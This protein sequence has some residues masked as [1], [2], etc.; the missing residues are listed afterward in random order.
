MK[1]A[2]NLLILL[3]LLCVGCSPS[4]EIQNSESEPEISESE[5]D[6]QLEE[7][8]EI[9][10]SNIPPSNAGQYPPAG[11][12]D[13]NGKMFYLNDVM[14]NTGKYSVNTIQMKKQSSYM[15]NVTEMR[16]V[17]LTITIMKNEYQAVMHKVPEVY[18]S[19][20]VN[21]WNDKASHTSEHDNGDS[22]VYTFD[23]LLDYRYY[24]I[25]NESSYAQY[26]TSITWTN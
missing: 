13:V 14:L 21:V 26:V 6:I 1:F 17:T 15:Y 22:I 12:Y 2:K 9:S 3:T 7:S 25:A 11:E 19:E 10:P 23:G 16:F 24:K 18:V 4:G 8:F 5:P 20:E